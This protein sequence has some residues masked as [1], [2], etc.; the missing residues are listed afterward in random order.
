MRRKGI[1]S[2][3]IGVLI[4]SNVVASGLPMIP[5]NTDESRSTN[6]TM[7]AETGCAQAEGGS[8]A[9]K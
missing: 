2:C 4:V 6:M 9:W 8:R 7:C 3:L 5:S 1:L